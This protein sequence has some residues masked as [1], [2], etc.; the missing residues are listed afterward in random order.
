MKGGLL[1][2]LTYKGLSLICTLI[3]L[4]MIA[5]AILHKDQAR[6]L[7]VTTA[8]VGGDASNIVLTDMIPTFFH[9]L[10]GNKPAATDTPG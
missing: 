5:T 1:T 4:M 3:V 6:S 10:A 9:H 8:V 7:G 2:G